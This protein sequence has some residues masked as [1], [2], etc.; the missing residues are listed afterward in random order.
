MLRRRLAVSGLLLLLLL[1]AG[2]VSNAAPQESARVLKGPWLQDLKTDGVTVLME[3]GAPGPATLKIR[4]E[5]AADWREIPF[6]RVDLKAST[7]SDKVR[8]SRDDAHVLYAASPGELKCGGQYEYRV[9]YGGKDAGGG[10]FGT[11]VPPGTAFRFAAYGDTRSGTEVHRGVA[12]AIL[13]TR[14]LFV[15]HTGDLVSDGTHYGDWEEQFFGPA[16]EML[17]NA[18]VYPVLGNH[19]Y[20]ASYFY[21]YFRLPGKAQFYWSLDCGDL[22]IIG[23]DPKQDGSPESDQVKWL[24]ED[25]DRSHARWKVLVVHYPPFSC[26]TMHESDLRTREVLQPVLR[27]HPVDLV[28]AGH[29]HVYERTRP[30][31]NRLDSK[32][33]AYVRGTPAAPKP[34]IHIVTGGGGAPL[35]DLA[36]QFWT[37]AS[38]S[39]AHFC[40]FEVTPDTLTMV[41]R[42]PDGTVIDR[43]TLG[44]GGEDLEKSLVYVEDIERGGGRP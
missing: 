11:R 25:I 34:V 43:L 17:M 28:I 33:R 20:N 32:G 14:P 23:I 1:P 35:Y 15:L 29:N 31:V 37:A 4:P 2:S 18:P 12:Q 44:K 9:L 40:D 19:D 26:C 42:E 41:A 21:R 27:D 30:I 3:T 38:K 36:R 16:R 13:K 24:R 6:A 39:A 22:H 5:G 10:R 7:A 8:E